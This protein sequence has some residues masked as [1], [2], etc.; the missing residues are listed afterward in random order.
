MDITNDGDGRSDVDD[1]TLLHQELF[2]FGA[3]RLDDGVS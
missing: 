1:V 3:Y 2:C